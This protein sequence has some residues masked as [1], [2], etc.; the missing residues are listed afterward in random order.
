[1]RE[2]SCVRNFEGVSLFNLELRAS[3]LSESA[4]QTFYGLFYGLKIL[5]CKT[6]QFCATRR[7]SEMAETPSVRNPVQRGEN[8]RKKSFLN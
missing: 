5:A 7:E 1:M 4:A 6:A 2:R 8:E 3:R